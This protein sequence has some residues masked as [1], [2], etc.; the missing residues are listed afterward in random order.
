MTPR[1]HGSILPQA[2]LSPGLP[3][4]ALSQAILVAAILASV[5]GGVVL[6]IR[7]SAG[8]TRMEIILPTA[9]VESQIELKV[10]VT[11]AVHSPGVYTVA[12]GDR[13]MAVVEAAGGVTEE[14]DLT[15]V[16]LAVRV[17]DEQHWHIPRQ[18]EVADILTEGGSPVEGS[19]SVAEGVVAEAAG[20][21]SRKI[22]LN[23][24]SAEDLKSLDGIGE[25]LAQRIV[26]YREANGPFT[27]VDDL[28][29]VRGIGSAILDKNRD[30]VEVR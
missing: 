22:D 11:W 23:S 2:P 4:R 12:E 26:D 21:G 9:T 20:G 1:E 19:E 5:A 29:K 27:N 13:L 18:G 6:L 24:A 7:D 16:N 28:T 17:K 25:V 15:A 8:G 10:Y 30:L 14:A 3:M